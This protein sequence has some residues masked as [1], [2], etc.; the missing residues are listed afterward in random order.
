MFIQTHFMLSTIS[1]PMLRELSHLT[2]SQKIILKPWLNSFGLL[3]SCHFLPTVAD[4]HKKWK[5]SRFRFSTAIVEVWSL[6]K[7]A[8][9]K[10]VERW[11]LTISNIQHC[12]HSAYTS[13]LSLVP[14]VQNP[15][16]WGPLMTQ[17]KR[18]RQTNFTR[19]RKRLVQPSP[20]TIRAK[21]IAFPTIQCCVGKIPVRKTAILL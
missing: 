8:E 16:P 4:R 9:N 7:V 3:L 1:V 10:V 19:R 2:S 21:F 5:L 14:V 12:S 15:P 20:N 17:L 6:G 13:S 11:V 18:H